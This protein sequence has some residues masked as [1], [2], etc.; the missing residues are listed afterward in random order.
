E[1]HSARSRMII[2]RARLVTPEL[3]ASSGGS[4]GLGRNDPLDVRV[5]AATSCLAQLVYA[6]SHVRVP[7]SGAFESTLS[8]A[9]TYRSPKFLAGFDGTDVRA[10]GVPIS[11]LF[12][13]IRLERRAFVLS[14]AGATLGKGE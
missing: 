11:S 14:N 12:G 5:H 6:V 2:D 3:T 7:V 1:L 9:G 13:E 4:L 10:N 8:I